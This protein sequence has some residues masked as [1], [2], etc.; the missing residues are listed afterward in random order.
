MVITH[1]SNLVRVQAEKYGDR[2]AFR[3]RDQEKGIWV[4]TSWNAF[5]CA[6][7]DLAKALVELG[8]KEQENIA[9]YTQNK[10]EGLILDFA[11]Y[12]NRAVVIPLYAT[13][14]VSQ[15]E[16]IVKIGRAHV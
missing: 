10:P 8:I 2:A 11:A 12:N 13:S 6:V 14:S 5:S 4:P 16:Y 1:F 7:D 3:H 9:T 15:I